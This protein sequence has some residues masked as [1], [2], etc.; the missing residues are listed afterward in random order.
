MR[1]MLECKF[2]KSFIENT[3]TLTENNPHARANL[4]ANQVSEQEFTTITLP[5]FLPR[6]M[7]Y[8]YNYGC[9]DA[10]TETMFINLLKCWGK[11]FEFF[12]VADINFA[13]GLCDMQVS[14][15]KCSIFIF[16]L[17]TPCSSAV[18]RPPLSVN[19]V[20]Q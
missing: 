1:Y 10:V 6:Y 5:L 13:F 11:L 8:I 3:V 9:Q 16:F 17:L 19:Y 4:N 20:L 14:S 15:L 2:P 7:G 18:A 12:E